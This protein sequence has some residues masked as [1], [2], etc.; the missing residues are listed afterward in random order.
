MVRIWFE[1]AIEKRPEK[2]TEYESE[3]DKRRELEKEKGGQID[4]GSKK[5]KAFFV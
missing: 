5:I 4:K 1:I 2:R 3:R